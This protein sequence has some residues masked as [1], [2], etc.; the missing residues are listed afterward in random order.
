MFSPGDQILTL[1]PIAGSPFLVKFTGP[2]TVVWE[3]SDFNYLISTSDHKR[4]MQLW[5]INLLKP[6]YSWSLVSGVADTGDQGKPVA[7]VAVTG[8]SSSS[9][10]MVAACSAEDV[11]GTND[12]VLQPW[13][14]N[15]EKLAELETLLGHLQM[16]RTSAVKSLISEFPFLFSD[17]PS[18][19]HLIEH[20]LDICDAEPIRQWFYQASPEKQHHREAEVMYLLDNG[21][22]KYSYS[23]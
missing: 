19:K 4:S 14:R 16:E 5:H 8:T 6:Y 18:C 21:L 23:S 22:A 2:Y 20:Y 17:T 12:C 9:P 15:S 1:L 11:V 13:L 10:Y 3:V 7:L